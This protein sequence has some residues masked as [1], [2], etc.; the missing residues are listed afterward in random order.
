MIE[1]SKIP[2]YVKRILK[3]FENE[4]KN[5]EQAS[6]EEKKDIINLSNSLYKT[7]KLLLEV[8]KIRRDRTLLTPEEK[9]SNEEVLKVYVSGYLSEMK[10]TDINTFNQI[11]KSYQTID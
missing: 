11:I 4:L 5:L 8:E 6:T 1:D 7:A 10:N 9:A 3:I 2:N